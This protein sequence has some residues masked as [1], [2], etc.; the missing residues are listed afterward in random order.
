[1]EEEQEDEQGVVV[2]QLSKR[3]DFLNGRNLQVQPMS[4]HV[5]V[6]LRN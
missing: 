2:D 4:S 5:R 3:Q 6:M 1:M